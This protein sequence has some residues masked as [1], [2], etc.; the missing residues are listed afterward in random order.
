MSQQ[1]QS[2]DSMMN[3]LKRTNHYTEAELADF[4]KAL[5]S[6]KNM[7]AQTNWIDIIPPCPPGSTKTAAVPF[8]MKI[9]IEIKS[10]TS[11]WSLE[12]KNKTFAEQYG[13]KE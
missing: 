7:P 4:R 1:H 10:L 11:G 5:E 9:P 2:I 12:E 13:P 8:D 6:V 3:Y